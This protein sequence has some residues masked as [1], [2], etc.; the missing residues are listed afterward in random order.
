M[1]VLLLQYYFYLQKAQ[2]QIIY[3]LQGAILLVGGGYYILLTLNSF[4][5]RLYA[6]DIFLGLAL[7]V[8]V[9]IYYALVYNSVLLVILISTRLVS[10]ILYSRYNSKRATPIKD[11]VERTFL[12]ILR[13]LIAL[14]TLQS[15]LI[16]SLISGRPLIHIYLWLNASSAIDIRE[17]PIG[18]WLN[19]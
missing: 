6:K 13:A 12:Y 18:S 5:F 15:A 7:Y 16:S 4:Y 2:S 8:R 9:R 10:A 19:T 1:T 14:I 3:Q 17:Y 11:Q